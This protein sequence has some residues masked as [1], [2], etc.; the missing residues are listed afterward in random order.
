MSPSNA[1]HGT[2]GTGCE[3]VRVRLGVLPLLGVLLVAAC[4][5]DD[6]KAP[7]T[8]AMEAPISPS[9]TPDVS[10]GVLGCDQVIEDT[11]GVPSGYETV[12]HTVA[13][14]TAQSAR[15]ALQVSQHQDQPAPNFFAKT[16]LLVRAGA[17]VSIEVNHP[18]DIALI[19]WGS[20]DE[21][22]SYVSSTGC[23]GQGW[24]AFPGGFLVREPMCVDLTVKVNSEQESIR[25]G[26]GAPCEGQQPPPTP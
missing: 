15:Q 2:S 12:L 4:S 9:A 21:F 26:A 14:P 18:P 8:A 5:G 19:G 23:G 7:D 10:A 17:A 13:L 3:S 22:V 20:A 25:V 6:E 16:G 24:L 11:T 1:D